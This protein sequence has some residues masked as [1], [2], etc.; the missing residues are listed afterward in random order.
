MGDC[1]LVLRYFALRDEKNIRGSMKAML[2]RAMESR[3]DISE[4]DSDSLKTEF[5]ERLK[6]ANDIF[7][8]NPFVLP[9][10]E[11]GRGRISAALYDA[12]LVA[13]DRLWQK[14]D[15]LVAAKDAIQDRLRD[16]FANEESAPVLTGQGNTA[17]AVRE[18]IGLIERILSEGA[19]L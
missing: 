5:A 10:D 8:P 7:G 13:V 15:K 16:E 19:G 6:V 12:T 2:D 18:R 9:P 17:Q 4:E 1:Q 14:R 11:K 3:M